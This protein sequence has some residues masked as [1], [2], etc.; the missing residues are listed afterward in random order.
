MPRETPLSAAAQ[1][2]VAF[3]RA[4]AVQVGLEILSG[5][6]RIIDER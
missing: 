2:F 5:R 1:S 4:Q 3:V 6:N